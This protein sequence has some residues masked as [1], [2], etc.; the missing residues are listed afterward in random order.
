M[1][2]SPIAR[3]GEQEPHHAVL[4]VGADEV[5]VVVQDGGHDAGGAVGRGGDHPAAGGVLL[6]DRQ[7]VEGHPVH[8]AERVG[9]VRM[10]LQL[11]AQRGRAPADLEPAG[12]HARWS[13]CRAPRTPASPTRCA[14]GPRGPRPRCARTSSL[15]SITSLIRSP[16][17]RVAGQQLLTGAERDSGRACGPRRCRV[18]GVVLV[19]DEPAADRV[20]LAPVDVGPRRR[21]ARNTMPLLW[22]S[23]RLRRCSTTSSS[24]ENAIGCSP[25]SASLPSRRTAATRGSAA[26]GS[27]RS[28]C[29]PSRPRTTALTL[30]WPCPVAPSDPNSS[31]RTAATRSR[32]PSSRSRETK[33]T[34]ARI[35]P[36]GVR[37]GRADADLEQVECADGHACL[38]PVRSTRAMQV[39]SDISDVQKAYVFHHKEASLARPQPLRFGRDRRHRWISMRPLPRPSPTRPTWR[40]RTS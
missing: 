31:Q 22:K 29:S 37:A 40:S 5:A 39:T 34:A 27:T 12:Q 26:T 30:P 6:V 9:L 32:R 3:G 10:V 36:D 2:S 13:G 1:N 28:G 16:V 8:R 11:G 14:A 23:S 35:G 33:G 21:A 38:S 20:V 25:A 7:G 18:A 24:T 17:S 19:E 4:G 15:A